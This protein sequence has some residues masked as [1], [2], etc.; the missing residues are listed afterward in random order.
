MN[1]EKT[2]SKRD[3]FRLGFRRASEAVGSLIDTSDSLAAV[4]SASRASSPTMASSAPKSSFVRPPGAIAEEPFLKACTSC[5]DCIR[6]CP[7][8][9]IRKAGPE[10]GETMEGTPIILPA[11]NPCLMCADFPCIAACES[12]ALTLVPD[13]FIRIGVARVD[14]AACYM[15]LG[16]PCDYC[17]THCPTRPKAIHALDRGMVAQ[18]EDDLCTGCGKCAEICPADAISIVD[19]RLE[20]IEG[21]DPE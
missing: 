20:P 12:G 15:A 10:L 5:D 3:L 1:R 19:H 14:D 6:A 17:M 18:V 8:W 4:G 21:R 16:Q 9:V 2:F 7:H 13:A 11:E